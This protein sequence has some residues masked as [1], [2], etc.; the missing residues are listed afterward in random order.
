MDGLT[1]LF[2]VHY[3]LHLTIFDCGVQMSTHNVVLGI[4]TF[5]GC[6]LQRLPNCLFKKALHALDGELLDE[7]K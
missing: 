5:V 2:E 7:Y 3:E 1:F 6:S 4:L